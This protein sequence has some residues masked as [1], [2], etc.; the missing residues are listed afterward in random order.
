MELPT[1][2]HALVLQ[3]TMKEVCVM[4]EACYWHD[5]TLGMMSGNYGIFS[6]RTSRYWTV[7]AIQ[8]CNRGSAQLMMVAERLWK[9]YICRWRRDFVWTAEKELFVFR[10]SKGQLCLKYAGSRMWVRIHVIDALLKLEPLHILDLGTLE[11]LKGGIFA[12]VS[13]EPFLTNTRCNPNQW[14]SLGTGN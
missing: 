11:M 8:V 12:Y 9:P 10:L 4:F 7:K 13:F 2:F 6:F 5:E 1:R 3:H 14:K